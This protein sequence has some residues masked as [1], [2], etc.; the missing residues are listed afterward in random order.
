MSVRT[1]E[2][3]EEGEDPLE[4][5]NLY[6]SQE[7]TSKLVMPREENSVVYSRTITIW[8]ITH[9]FVCTFYAYKCAFN[10][11]AQTLIRAKE[12]FIH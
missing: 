10:G 11:I 2:E 12:P 4:Y 9:E 5:W 1:F 8:E 3:D 6:P 7:K